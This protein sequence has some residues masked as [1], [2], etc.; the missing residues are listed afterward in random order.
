MDKK[1]RTL[2]PLDRHDYPV[3]CNK[4]RINYADAIDTTDSNLKKQ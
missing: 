2:L 1:R 4:V 3:L